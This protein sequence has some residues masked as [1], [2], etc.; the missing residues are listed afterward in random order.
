MMSVL[1]EPKR[2][3]A[4][5]LMTAATCL[6]LDLDASAMIMM[7]SMNWVPLTAGYVSTESS[8]KSDE[9]EVDS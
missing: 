7:Y 4:L 3:D 5:V 8:S 1:L 9:E 2:K 6:G